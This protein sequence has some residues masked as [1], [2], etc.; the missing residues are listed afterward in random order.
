MD[1]E[2]G[3]KTWRQRRQEKIE[4][5]PSYQAAKEVAGLLAKKDLSHKEAME[6]LHYAQDV[7]SQ[8]KLTAE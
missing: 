1:D 5:T 4:A 2:Q 6:A 3:G 7:I 8:F